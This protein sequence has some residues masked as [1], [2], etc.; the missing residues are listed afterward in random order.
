V[1]ANDSAAP[2]VIAYAARD[3]TRTWLK[4]VAGKR[5]GRLVVARTVAEFSAIFRSELVDAALVD[6]PASDES[7]RVAGL[8]LEYPS[9]AFLG[10]TSFRA[11]DGP[12]LARWAKL[13]FADLIAEGVD[14]SVV[15]ELVARY[16]YSARFA[17]ALASP[18]AA[19]SLS[20]ALQLAAWRFVVARGGRLTRTSAVASALGL[21]RE[22]LS[23]SFGPSGA[24]TLKRLID[25]VRLLSA[26]E[27][28]KNP[29]YDA[30]DIARLLKFSSSAHLSLTAQRLIGRR[31]S[32]LAAMRGVDV[33]DR[34]VEHRRNGPASDRTRRVLIRRV[35]GRG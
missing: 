14:E 12:T 25:L 13:D 15:P 34:F 22:H 6:A 2:L 17:A 8:A 21:T 7:D 31:A 18:P 11:S 16:G 10:V 9:V 35:S 20:S 28:A 3:R 30:A 29:G 33:I 27:L 19:L 23:R 24:P 4:R 1:H 32:S 5:V 26:A